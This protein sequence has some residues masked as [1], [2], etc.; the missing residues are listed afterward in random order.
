VKKKII[1]HI[2][3]GKTGTT[4]LQDFFWENRGQLEKAGVFYPAYGAVAHAHQLLSPY[5][6]K[7]KLKDQWPF[8]LPSE[9]MP[10]LQ[11]A[12]HDRIL[13]SSEL[14][15]WASADQVTEFCRCVQEH[16]DLTIVIYVRRQ[17]N[18]IMA[19][20]NQLVKAGSQRRE[21][22]KIW[23]KDLDRFN[24]RKIIA[25]WS[26]CLGKAQII[27]RPYE[28]QQ[29]YGCDIRRDFMQHV[30]GAEVSAEYVMPSG[31]SNPRLN[32][33]AITYKLHLCRLLEDR[34][35]VARFNESLLSYSGEAHDSSDNIFLDQPLL[36]PAVRS[37]II[38]RSSAINEYIAREYLGNPNG[39]LFL[40]PLP[41]D[42]SSWR[43]PELTGV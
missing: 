34:D 10:E 29:F 39:K 5:R 21:I 36:S 6:P 41:N 38:E 28:K 26:E 13:L 23:E 3:M 1:L 17:D 4:A 7:K 35:Q 42:A 14:I 24:Y 25:P 2:G 33:L 40:E 19:N 20:Y 9:W 11:K 30:F 27:V 43:R 15:A 32:S 37:D 31:N 18:I 16:F 8:K 12:T 22:D